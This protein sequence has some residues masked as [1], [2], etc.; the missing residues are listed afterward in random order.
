MR[1]CSLVLLI[2]LVGCADRSLDIPTPGVDAAEPPFDLAV[3]T[4]VCAFAAKVIADDVA[5]GTFTFPFDGDHVLYPAQRDAAWVLVS[6]AKDGS[7]STVVGDYFTQTIAA[8]DHHAYFGTQA[9]PRTLFDANLETGRVQAIGSAGTAPVWTIAIASDAIVF[10]EQAQLVR[11]DRASGTLKTVSL[12]V[13]NGSL[14]GAA[15]LGRSAVYV[16][17]DD[18]LM[19]YD[20][21]GGAFSALVPSSMYV[22]TLAAYD[23]QVLVAGAVQSDAPTVVTAV[24]SDGTLA[25]AGVLPPN[26]SLFAFDAASIYSTGLEGVIIHETSRSGGG[27]CTFTLPS[28]S[29]ISAMEFDDALYLVSYTNV[30]PPGPQPAGKLWRITTTN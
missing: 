8:D 10:F 3:S 9:T 1:R 12:P 2:T 30:P 13:A 21:D 29:G 15:I 4:P 16:A 26:D 6:V 24:A 14:N 5:G 28:D 18:S 27:V 20:L 11:F 7:Q 19:A 25:S 22:N 23:G 17:A